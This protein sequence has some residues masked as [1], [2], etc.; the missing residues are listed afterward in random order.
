MDSIDP[1]TLLRLLIITKETF[2]YIKS[3]TE[4]SE[5]R[6]MRIINSNEHNRNALYDRKPVNGYEDEEEDLFLDG[7]EEKFALGGPTQNW[8]FNKSK[9]KTTKK[10]SKNKFKIPSLSVM[11]TRMVIHSR[12]VQ[13][14]DLK[15]NSMRNHL[16]HL[17]LPGK[18]IFLDPLW[19]EKLFQSF[20][21]CEDWAILLK[22]SM[23]FRK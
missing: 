14:I 21:V 12:F 11:R 17:N 16:E 4:A 9:Q 15:C 22:N 13:L 3:L 6:E 2:S 23:S 1:I 8:G 10:K 20:S 5:K 18:F 19:L 7:A